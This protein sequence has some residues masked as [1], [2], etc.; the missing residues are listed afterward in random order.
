VAA[1]VSLSP[2]GL[3][4]TIVHVPLEFA[5][6]LNPTMWKRQTSLSSSWCWSLAP[7]ALIFT[8]PLLPF[9]PPVVDVPPDVPVFPPPLLFPPLLFPPLLFPPELPPELDVPPEV[10]VEVDV[11]PEVPVLPAVHLCFPPLTPAMSRAP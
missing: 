2:V 3:Q 1:T 6:K 7:A 9:E 5:S 10:P 11:L 8:S 4:A